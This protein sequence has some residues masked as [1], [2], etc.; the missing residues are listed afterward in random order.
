MGTNELVCTPVK[1]VWLED[2][3]DGDTCECGRFV[4]ELQSVF[5]QLRAVITQTVPAA[6]RAQV[7]KRED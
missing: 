6:G 7:E 1:H 2:F 3:Y 5:R 4:L